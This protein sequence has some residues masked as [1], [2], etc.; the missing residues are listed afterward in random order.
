MDHVR[1]IG[2]NYI[3][4][5]YCGKIIQN[6]L[7]NLLANKVKQNIVCGALEAK[8]FSV[9]VDCTPDVSHIEQLLITIFL[10]VLTDTLIKEH[11]LTHWQARSSTGEMLT[12]IILQEMS[13]C[14]LDMNNCR[15]QGYDNFT[16]MIGKHK[17]V[18]T[19]INNL[20][21][22]AFLNPC[23]CHSSNLVGDAAKSSVKSVSL[24]GALQRLYI[25][26]S[27]SPKWWWLLK[28]HIINLTL[29]EVCETHREC[30]I[31]LIDV[32]EG[33][34]KFFH[35]YRTDGFKNV[36]KIAKE[37]AEQL[38][39]DPVFVQHQSRWKK[40]FFS[41]EGTDASSYN[42]EEIFTRDVFFPLVDTISSAIKDCFE[43]LKIHNDMW[44]LLDNI[45][46]LPLREDLLKHCMH[47]QENLK[48]VESADVNGLELCEELLHFQYLVYQNSVSPMKVL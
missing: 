35:Q 23:G 45:K 10:V 44:N 19:R 29:K 31:G 40:I 48:F 2:N 21:A 12:N 47:M 7:I 16:N 14:K 15:G 11:F 25:L 9:I 20:Y 42:P 22:R 33:C 34:T 4:N 8:F 32:M 6:E 41:Y 43:Q 37:T 36:R 27:A 26:F 1:K 24:F 46:N 3:H 17:G 5:H 13:S 28:T 38:E 39:V 30:R 18:R